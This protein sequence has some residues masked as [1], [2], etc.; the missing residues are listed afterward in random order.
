[1]TQA[2]DVNKIN[3]LIEKEAPQSIVEVA[4]GIIVVKSQYIA[5][6]CRALKE[7]KG[8]EFNYLADLTAK[9]NNGYME[10]VYQIVSLEL[11]HSASIKARTEG[12]DNPKVPSVTSIWRGA[13]MQEREVYDLFGI[14]FTGHPN[15]K[16]IL[17][18]EGFEGH[19]LRKDHIN[20]A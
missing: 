20:D 8:F 4:N 16:R 3:E 1:M 18:W 11:N 17:L 7:T 13:D 19:P 10:V 14:T 9:D 6:I 12:R 2:L 15:L 5:S